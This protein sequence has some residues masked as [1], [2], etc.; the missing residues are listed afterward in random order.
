MRLKRVL[1]KKIKFVLQII[2]LLIIIVLLIN[3]IDIFRSTNTDKNS[4]IGTDS[5]ISILFCPEQNCLNALINEITHAKNSIYCAVYDIDVDKLKLL[6]DLNKKGLDVR[7]VSD[8]RQAKRKNSIVKFLID[9][10]IARVDFEEK[11]YMHNKFC[12]FDHNTVWVGSANFTNNGFFKNNNNIVIVRDSK[13]A[14]VFEEEFMELWNGVFNGGKEN[15]L[16]SKNIE[17]Y[18]C[19]E[20]KCMEKVLEKL[21]SANKSIYCMAFSF[22]HNKM[23]DLLIK[24]FQKGV[25]IKVIFESRQ[26]SKY[27]AYKDL[28]NKEISVIKDKNNAT[29]HN[30][31][32]II[33]SNIVI[34]GSMNFSKHADEEND[35]SIIILKDQNIASAYE[36]YFGKYWGA[37]R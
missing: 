11:A 29:M 17:A 37:W 12:I 7:I 33:D 35:E 22:T 30:K 31:F 18:F 14:K 23:K 6:A 27:S 13:I 9:N 20:D 8:D 34:T 21:N 5:N 19:P 4:V 26:I 2:A 32:C 15:G 28:A 3:N 16:V 10:N 25:D 36:N 24:K 1:I